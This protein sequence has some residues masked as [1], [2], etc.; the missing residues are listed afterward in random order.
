MA[1]PQ[2]ERD[3]VR[4]MAKRVAQVAAD[5][6]QQ[7]KLAEWKRHN[8]LKPGKPMVLQAPEGVWDEFVPE[9]S[10]VC[11]DPDC[12]HIEREMRWRQYRIDHLRDDEPIVTKFSSGVAAH[13]TGFGLQVETT[14][15]PEAQG[16]HGACHYETTLTEDADPEEVFQRRTV[17]I[18][19][20]AT[21]QAFDR[22]S[23]LVG[24]I[25]DVS[26][27]GVGCNWFAPMDM[28]LQ[29]RG[30]D[31]L[32]LDLMDRPEWIHRIMAYLTESEIALCKQVEELDVLA[33]N[34]YANYVG[35]GGIGA[36]DELPQSDFDG[37]VRLKDVWGMATAQIFSEVSPAMHDEFAIAYEK[38]FLEPFGLTCYGCCEPLHKKI[39]IL[40]KIPNLRRISMSPWI[41][42]IEGAEKI[43][44][45]YIFS[46]KPNPAY[47]STDRWDLEV[48]RQEM[49][50]VLDACK[51]NGCTSEYV[52]KDTHTCRGEPERY[53]QW[54][55][56]AMELV[57]DYA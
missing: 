26:P 32:L 3:L 18:D 56:M 10:L 48:C 2:K 6:I 45:D 34:N 12:R 52:M 33:M 27:G 41:E 25:L 51:A 23:D 9:S 47:L 54:T 57:L 28:L 42:P 43:G 49:I 15:N 5:P 36:T 44:S 4:D 35:S 17:T 16:V 30:P 37:H 1:A 38:Q 40:R 39:D 29:W 7:T 46:F 53:D 31:K 11:E 8:S 19:E 24:D 50:A 20:E 21:Q 55:E 22:I 13:F 14:S